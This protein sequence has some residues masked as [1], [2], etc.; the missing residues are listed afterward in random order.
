[1]KWFGGPTGAD[2]ASAEHVRTVFR[3]MLPVLIGLSIMQVNTLVDSALAW[4]LVPESSGMHVAALR[5]F[6][7]PEGTASALYLGQRLFQFPMGVFGIALSTV[8]FPR[9]ARHARAGDSLQLNRDILHGLQ[10]V[11]V[12]GIPASA[13][14]VFMAEPITDLLFRHGQFSV[15][16]SV[17]TSRMIAAHGVG[18]WVFCGLLIVNRVFY[19]AGDQQTPMRQGLTCVGLNLVFNVALIPVLGG[20]A[21]A[22]AGVLAA[23]F[24]FGLALEVLRKRRYLS[25]CRGAMVAV[26]WRGV[27]G[28]ILMTVA[29]L[30]VLGWLSRQ[31]AVDDDLL[32]RVVQVV[33]PIASAVAVYATT[34][35]LTG[36]SPKR[37]LNEPFE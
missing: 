16:D 33:L 8:L 13:G 36:I 18:V 31:A 19:A 12:V 28:A 7:L 9:F 14:L 17:L 35:L 2:G 30:G 26:L 34:L 22:L 6:R 1:V 29:G 37:L 3:T 15:A 4:A 25:K 5:P 32:S 11:M 20:A 24:Q 23:V 27:L 21:L 10:L